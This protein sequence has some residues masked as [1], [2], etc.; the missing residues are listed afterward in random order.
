MS[1][2]TTVSRM[3][4]CLLVICFTAAALLCLKRAAVPCAAPLPGPGKAVSH[5][6]IAKFSWW[7]QG[8]FKFYNEGLASWPFPVEGKAEKK[9]CLSA[10]LGGFSSWAGKCRPDGTI[11]FNTLWL[12]HIFCFPVIQ[13][14]GQ[15]LW[16]QTV[17]VH[18][19]LHID[20]SAQLQ[21]Y[22]TLTWSWIH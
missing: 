7:G 22:S 1:V 14:I 13:A 10:S 5:G 9:Q 4:T 3:A 11:L 2:E 8:L 19:F 17:S 20:N 12:L 16:G 18:P 6:P 21:T 15:K